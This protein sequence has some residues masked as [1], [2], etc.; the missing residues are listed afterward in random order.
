MQRKEMDKLRLFM[1]DKVNDLSDKLGNL[2]KQF[3]NLDDEGK[4]FEEDVRETYK[5]ISKLTRILRESS[6]AIKGGLVGQITSNMQNK[7]LTGNSNS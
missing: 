4:K 5:N 3:E 1:T 7:K 6:P 2:L